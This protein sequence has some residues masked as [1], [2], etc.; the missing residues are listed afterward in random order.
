MLLQVGI[1]PPSVLQAASSSHLHVDFSLTLLLHYHFSS[2]LT[3]F[4]YVNMF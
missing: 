2:K 3:F 4:I 1:A